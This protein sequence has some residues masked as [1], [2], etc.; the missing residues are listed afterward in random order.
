MILPPV[1]FCRLQRAER[2]LLRLQRIH[3]AALRALNAMVRSTPSTSP[4]RSNFVAGSA[5]SCLWVR[6]STSRVPRWKGSSTRRSL[7]C[8][9]AL[10]SRNSLHGKLQ[11]TFGT[12]SARKQDNFDVMLKRCELSSRAATNRVSPEMATARTSVR[13]GNSAGRTSPWEYEELC[14]RVGSRQQR[15]GV[16]PRSYF[17]FAG[18][19]SSRASLS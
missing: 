7:P 3:S 16:P 10:T 4:V 17:E 2:H 11:Q 5:T 6:W 18:R 14:S 13:S 8:R 9:K 19:N 15:F 1:N 12:D